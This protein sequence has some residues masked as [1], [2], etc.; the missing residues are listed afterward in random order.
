[1][2]RKIFFHIPGDSA[3]ALYRSTLPHLH[4]YHNLSKQ[5]INLVGADK[6]INNEEFDCYVFN[7]V[8]RTDFYNNYVVKLIEKNKD[9][10][11][12]TDDDLWNI[13][14]WNPSS[15]LLGKNDLEV[16]SKY[17]E[18]SSLIIISTE[19]LRKRFIGGNTVVL[20]NLID[21]NYFDRPQIKKP[22]LKILWCGSVSH[23]A[24]FDDVIEPIT[25]IL[26]KYKEIA[27]IF[28]GYLP[29]QLANFIREPGFPHASLAP[30]YPNL[31]FGEW[32]DIRLYFDKLVDLAP[33]IALIPLND[34]EFNK[35]KSNLKFLEMSMAGAA[36]I[37]SDLEPYKCI[38][39]NETGL[40]ASKPEEW[41]D[42][43]VELI[44]NKDL[45]T[46]IVKNAQV[47]I[48]EEYSWQ[49]SKQKLWENTLAQL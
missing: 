12:Q 42:Y 43:L 1:M 39:H 2:S 35:N 5:G 48:K 33:D 45:R 13:P 47:Q 3:C 6:T 49:C 41:Y 27:V 44:E 28:W 32:F 38:K 40:L 22:P 30:K 18:N 19:P 11:W 8:I 14:S 23:H 17:I 16:T 34:C 46:K 4:C 21:I 25:K 24:D 37:A 36:C 20:P 7:R 10:V 9:L 26:E 15:K 29:T 31:Y